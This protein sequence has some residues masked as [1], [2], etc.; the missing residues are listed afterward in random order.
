[1]YNIEQIPVVSFLPHV[2]RRYL[3]LAG[4]MVGERKASTPR[5][6]PACVEAQTPVGASSHLEGEE[7]QFLRNGSLDR[8]VLSWHGAQHEGTW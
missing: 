5:Y 1:M 7:N 8:L 2:V 4:S 6:M 3:A